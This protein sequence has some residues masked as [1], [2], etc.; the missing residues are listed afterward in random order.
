MII[1]PMTSPEMLAWLLTTRS[2]DRTIAIHSASIEVKKLYN[3]YYTSLVLLHRPC[4][5]CIATEQYTL[6]YSQNG[7]GGQTCRSII[8]NWDGYCLCS[9]LFWL[10]GCMHYALTGVKSW[11]RKNLTAISTNIR[12]HKHNVVV[13]PFKLYLSINSLAFLVDIHVKKTKCRQ[14][15][16]YI[17][18]S[19]LL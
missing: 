14:Y 11:L 12:V 18:H 10:L 8:W 17:S 1:R 13:A 15:I 3:K 16:F 7:C 9:A 19:H 2:T 4:W 6:V 5:Y